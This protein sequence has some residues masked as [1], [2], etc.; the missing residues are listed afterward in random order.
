MSTRRGRPREF[1]TE[2]ALDRALEVFWRKGYEGASL[3]DLTAA[4]GI[5]R[6]S[7]YAAY[8]SKQE[9][10]QRAIDRYLA[11]PAAHVRAALQEPTARKVAERMLVGGIALVTSKHNPPG[12]FLV[13]GALVCGDHA[14]AA[15]TALD[16]CRAA[17]ELALRKR[18]ERA[19][20]EGDLPPTARPRELAR[21]ITTLNYGLAVQAAGGATRAQ[22]E[23][24]AKLALDAWPR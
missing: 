7:L 10:F 12:C 11:G 15:R 18:F 20:K 14:T 13:H 6:P 3:P 2:Q 5:S 19:L 23:A 4:M 22:L 17:G 16:H 24:V 8:G 9:L 1:C 21:W